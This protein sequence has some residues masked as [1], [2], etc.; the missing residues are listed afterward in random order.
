MLY[1]WKVLIVVI[2]LT[3][4][5]FMVAK[6]VMCR[7]MSAADFAVRR[8]VWL[9]INAAAFLIPN[10]WGYVLAASLFFA[11]GLKRDSN[12]AALYVFLLLA[13]TPLGLN[14]PTLGVV[15]Q[16][17]VL[18]HFRLLALV[19]L[20]PLAWRHRRDKPA[21]AEGLLVVNPADRATR[22]GD[23]LILVYAALQLVLLMPYESPT[24][25]MRRMLL[26][27]LD[28]LLPYYVLSR[29]C[30]SR[31]AVADVMAA[32]AL[33]L[34]LL[35][36]LAA[37]EVARHSLLY[38]VLQETWGTGQILNVLERA[39]YLRAQVT[40]GHSIV[41][42]YAMAMAMGF[43]LYLQTRV[44]VRGWRWLGFAALTAGLALALARGPWVGALTIVFLYLLL[45]P[46]AASRLM[47]AFGWLSALAVLALASPFGTKIIA[48]LPFIGTVDEGTI[49]YRQQLA[50][51]S[52]LLI[53]H[54]PLFG[55]PSYLAYME[56]LRQGQGIIDMVNAYANIALSFGL[57]SLAVFLSFFIVI[58]W[59]CVK[60]MRA[61]SGQDADLKLMGASIVASM[62]GGL[63]MIAT[64][65]LYLSIAPFTWALAGLASGFLVVAGERLREEVSPEPLDVDPFT[66][67]Q[68]SEIIG[69]ARFE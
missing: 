67:L 50:Q 17:F 26:L 46:N 44:E 56:D 58:I 65:N 23:V 41:L 38:P 13:M 55:T 69:G 5:S 6:P 1:Q 37:Y 43:W 22:A 66:G 53:Q 24:A 10:Y 31:E 29:T 2:V 40:A 15:K 47:K 61:L 11:Y 57:V 3:T 49:D 30:R 48:S 42:G 28:M 36:P 25:S 52:W 60:T 18:D 8:N 59:R 14:L 9:G 7:F 62:L 33:S 45:S 68:A 64:V 12:P 20:L 16:I 63:A 39:G 54:N 19:L 51:Q 4:L 27:G 35:V 21:N 32:F 34:L